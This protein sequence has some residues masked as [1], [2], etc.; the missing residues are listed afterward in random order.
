MHYLNKVTK[1]NYYEFSLVLNWK[2]H[3]ELLKFL[4]SVLQ[5]S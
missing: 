3:L 2:H 5:K 1:K 4:M